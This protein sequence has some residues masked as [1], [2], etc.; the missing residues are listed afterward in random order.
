VTHQILFV[1]GDGTGTHDDWDS[2]LVESLRDAFGPS[3]E[4]RY[5][6]LPNEADPNDAP[7][8]AVLAREFA[9]LRDGAILVGHSVGGTIL[10]NALA[11]AAMI[12]SLSEDS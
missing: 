11:E 7:W 5:P 2:R 12:K 1:Q 4:I 9:G 3:C 10:I 6:R 8:K